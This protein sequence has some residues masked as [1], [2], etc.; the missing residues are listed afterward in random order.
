LE[1]AIA[2][3]EP[4]L[5]SPKVKLL[6]DTR[7]TATLCFAITAILDVGDAHEPVAFDAL[8][9]PSTLQYAVSKSLLRTI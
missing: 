5:R 3:H 4:R 6:V 1:L 2:R 7:A 9:K 8:L